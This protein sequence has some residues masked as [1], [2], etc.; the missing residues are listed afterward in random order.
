MPYTHYIVLS[1]EV[2]FTLFLDHSGSGSQRS[3]P[4]PIKEEP[5]LPN[6]GS[7]Y[8]SSNRLQYNPA[9]IQTRRDSIDV[10]AIMHRNQ[11]QNHA[12]HNNMT[13]QAPPEVLAITRPQPVQNTAAPPLPPISLPTVSF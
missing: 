6:I 11:M 8:F 10:E 4:S 1:N 7:Q 9:C 5:N 2:I 3:T 12:N 13:L